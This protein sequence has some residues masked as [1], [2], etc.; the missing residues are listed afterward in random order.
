MS[1]NRWRCNEC[2]WH[3]F[4]EQLLEAPNPFDPDGCAP[5][6]GCP[7]CK[8]IN[9]FTNVCDEPGCKRDAGCGW[10]SYSQGYRRT[11]F[12]HMT[13]GEKAGDA[14]PSGWTGTAVEVAP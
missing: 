7:T 13:A 5:V 2:G 11:C 3:G 10:P 9:E 1:G 6:L 8:S 4:S 14:A 12:E